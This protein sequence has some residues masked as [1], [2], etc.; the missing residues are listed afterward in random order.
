VIPSNHRKETQYLFYD[1]TFNGKVYN[2]IIQRFGNMYGN[3]EYAQ[4][5]LLVS[6]KAQHMPCMPKP[7]MSHQRNRYVVHRN[8]SGL[9]CLRQ[10]RVSPHDHVVS[11]DVEG[12]TNGIAST[13]NLSSSSGSSA[14]GKQG[15]SSN[16]LSSVLPAGD[17][18]TVTSLDTSCASLV[19]GQRSFGLSSSPAP[20]VAMGVP[21][22]GKDR[23]F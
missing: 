14:R 15:T 6:N 19:T 10:T 7:I 4:S 9:L 5:C 2:S 21:R 3:G 17:N 8:S 12:S 22:V 20:G 18:C 13:G 23:G 1:M 11:A 16:S